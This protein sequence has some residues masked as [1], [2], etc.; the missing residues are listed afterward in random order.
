MNRELTI[1]EIEEEIKITQEA[2]AEAA[3]AAAA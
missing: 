2:A 3:R 1:R